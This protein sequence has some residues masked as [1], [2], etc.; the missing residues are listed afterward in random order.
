[1]VLLNAHKIA[2]VYYS[3]ILADKVSKTL[4]SCEMYAKKNSLK[5]ISCISKLIRC[6]MII[7]AE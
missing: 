2:Y 1:M 6:E 7:T 5:A 3:E 4:K